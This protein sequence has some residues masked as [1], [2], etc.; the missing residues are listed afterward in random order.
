MPNMDDVIEK[1][2]FYC[3]V[4]R[5]EDEGKQLN[6]PKVDVPEKKVQLYNA[7]VTL[8]QE[9]WDASAKKRPQVS[10]I[11][12]KLLEMQK[13]LGKNSDEDKQED[14]KQSTQN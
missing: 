7:Y 14:S 1:Y 13:M 5:T 6:M 2:N 3:N 4:G 11:L 10:N 12:E 9:C 8:M